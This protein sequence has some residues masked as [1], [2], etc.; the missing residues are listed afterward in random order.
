[1]NTPVKTTFAVLILLTF[2]CTKE[3]VSITKMAG[4]QNQESAALQLTAHYV[5]ERFGGGKI[6]YIDESGEHGLIADTVD[7]G[8]FRWYKESAIPT[9]ANETGIGS[10]KRNTSKIISAQ[11]KPAFYAAFECIRSQSSGY[12][13]WF[14]P[15]QDELNELYKHKD[16][17]G[18]FA[19]AYYWSSSEFNTY[20]A[21]TQNF[22]DGYQTWGYKYYSRNVRAIR[23]F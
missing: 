1:M 22:G 19:Y 10:G 3:R 13:D 20:S 15:S 9:G 17:I 23:A 11:G 6:F 5:G 7:L 18:G 2:S 21:R 16:L 8:I 12:K 4:T 14:L